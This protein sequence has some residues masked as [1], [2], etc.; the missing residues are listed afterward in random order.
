MLSNLKKKQASILTTKTTS[1]KTTTLLNQAI[2]LHQ[3]GNLEEAAVCYQKILETQPENFDA[4]HLLGAI[5]S[6]RKNHKTAIALIEQ[7]ITINPN[8]ARAHYNLGVALQQLKQLDSAVI[9]YD[10]ALALQ[11]HY[12]AAISNRNKAMEELGA[13]IS[14][15]KN[16]ETN[17]ESNFDVMFY[18]SISLRFNDETVAQQAIGGSEFVLWQLAQEM[19]RRGMKVLVQL[20]RPNGHQSIYQNVTYRYGPISLNLNVTHL[21]HH[22]YS[23]Q[24]YMGKVIW[25]TRSILCS[26]LWGQY[27][28]DLQSMVVPG[29]VICVSQWQ[30]AHFP[31]NWFV[32]TIANPLPSQ[33]YE[34][35]ELIRD[36]RVFLYASAALKGLE[37]TLKMWKQVRNLY[38]ELR[39]SR[40]RVLSPGYDDPTALCLQQYEGVEFVGALPFQQVL[41]EF[42]CAAGLFFVNSFPETFCIT[43]ALAE[44]TGARVHCWTQNGGAISTTVQSP[45]VSTSEEAFVSDFVKFYKN[46]SNSGVA[47]PK[48]YDVANIVDLWLMHFS[49]LSSK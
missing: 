41:N 45:L 14:S 4:L 9:S 13:A 8:N 16:D 44:A 1:T 2:S 3:Q 11:A 26:D 6:Q 15:V 33:A 27:Y 36:P 5:A 37:A 38:P 21:V 30:S 34:S 47:S 31:E 25:K 43:A 49:N 48:R 42:R 32:K 39:D 17:I 22:R 19:G 28:A 18:D 20:N 24:S 46:T 7:A 40:L 29:N 23:D 12:P 10:K 35:S